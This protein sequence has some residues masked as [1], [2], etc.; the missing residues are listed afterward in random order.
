LFPV[1]DRHVIQRDQWLHAARP[2]RRP[3]VVRMILGFI[4]RLA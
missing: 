1:S 4:P 2:V 3:L